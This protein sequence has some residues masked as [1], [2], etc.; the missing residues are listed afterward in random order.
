MG[1]IYTGRIIAVMTNTELTIE[2][3]T[4]IKKHKKAVCHHHPAS[5]LKRAIAEPIL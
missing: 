4:G 3:K 5:N 1:W 2:V